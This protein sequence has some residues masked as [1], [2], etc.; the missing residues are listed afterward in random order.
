MAGPL[1]HSVGKMRHAGG[2]EPFSS[3][4]AGLACTPHWKGL[5]GAHGPP[6]SS[7]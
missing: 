5:V 3:T 6:E 1:V 2:G 7:E 4:A